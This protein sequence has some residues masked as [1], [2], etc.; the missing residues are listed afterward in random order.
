VQASEQELDSFLA[1]GL[2][3]VLGPERYRAEVERRQDDARAASR[4]LDEALRANLVLGGAGSRTPEQLILAWPELTM[5]EKRAVVRAYIE[6]VTVSKADP[7]RRRWQPISER[8]ALS[9]VGE[10][11]SARD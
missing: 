4:E 6:R 9:W 10:L 11:D 2:A 8:V 3:S 5:E 1:T 7:K